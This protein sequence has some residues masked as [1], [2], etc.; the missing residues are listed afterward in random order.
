LDAELKLILSIA[1]ALA[2]W[3]KFGSSE[4]DNMQKI[5]DSTYRTKSEA[6]WQKEMR[7]AQKNWHDMLDVALNNF[8]N[9][10]DAEGKRF[11]EYGAP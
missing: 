1:L 2:W 3:N 5:N 6:N 10:C 8:S 4:F 9:R 7:N 11:V